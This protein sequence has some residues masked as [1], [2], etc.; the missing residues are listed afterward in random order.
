M[1]DVKLWRYF[2]Y[3]LDTPYESAESWQ[4][5]KFK[6]SETI[7]SFT[8]ARHAPRGCFPITTKNK[9]CRPIVQYISSMLPVAGFS[10]TSTTPT[11]TYST[12]VVIPIFLATSWMLCTSESR[13]NFRLLHPPPLYWSPY[14]LTVSFVLLS[15][16]DCKITS[17]IFGEEI[18]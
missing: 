2:W 8:T 9:H 3:C 10:M 17:S 15:A 11:K 14:L 18:S 7:P 5:N 4:T 6:M 16:V 13:G 1:G 12:P